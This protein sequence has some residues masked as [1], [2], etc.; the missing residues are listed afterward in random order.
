MKKTMVEFSVVKRS[1]GLT[2][3]GT[4]RQEVETRDI[5]KI[6]WPDNAYRARFLDEE[7]FQCS[8]FSKYYYNEAKYIANNETREVFKNCDNPF[9]FVITKFGQYVVLQEGDVVI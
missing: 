9:G 4:E 2:V 7:N 3:F 5:S 6:E 1:T 8:N